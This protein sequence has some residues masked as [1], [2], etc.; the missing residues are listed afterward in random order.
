MTP[1]SKTMGPSHFQGLGPN[2]AFI[3]TEK[4]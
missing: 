3:I 2:E 4:H 1:L